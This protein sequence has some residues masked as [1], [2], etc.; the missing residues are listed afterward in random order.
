MVEWESLTIK[1]LADL[2]Q[3]NQQTLRNWVNA[4]ELEYIQVGR[5]KRIP[6]KPLSRSRVATATKCQSCRSL[7]YCE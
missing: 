5:A 2:L 4:G 6:G 7:N 3:L 1:E